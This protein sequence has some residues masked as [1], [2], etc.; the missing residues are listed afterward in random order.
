M[1]AKSPLAG[2]V[3]RM[4][5]HGFLT[6]RGG[7]SLRR[8]RQAF[9]QHTRVARITAADDGSLRRFHGPGDPSRRWLT[10]EPLV[11]RF[12]WVKTIPSQLCQPQ[13]ANMGLTAPPDSSERLWW[14]G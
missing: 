12:R 2:A 14:R 8:P 6:G 4:W 5:C 13:G 10:T 1:P 11:T 9:G 7:R 3:L